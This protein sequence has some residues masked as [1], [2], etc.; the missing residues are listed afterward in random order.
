MSGPISAYFRW[1]QKVCDGYDAGALRAARGPFLW[2]IGLAVGGLS[3]F[4]VGGLGGLILGLVIAGPLLVGLLGMSL[5]ASQGVLSFILGI[6]VPGVVG[7]GAL[8]SFILIVNALW[9]V[10]Q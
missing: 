5:Y 1:V 10:G 9:G 2:V 6:V 8:V 4:T 7:V 3:G